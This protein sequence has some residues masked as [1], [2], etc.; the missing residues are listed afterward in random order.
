MSV[1]SCVYFISKTPEHILIEVGIGSVHLSC[2]ADLIL[3]ILN[4]KVMKI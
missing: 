3:F 2:E 1:H 4:A